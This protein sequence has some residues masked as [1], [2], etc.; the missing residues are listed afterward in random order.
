ME[1]ITRKLRFHFFALIH[2]VDLRYPLSNVVHFDNYPAVW[3]EHFILNGL[4]VD[5]PVLHASTRS[6]IG[7]ARAAVPDMV[8]LTTR[9]RRILERAAR[10]GIGPDFTVPS[11]MPGERHASCSFAVRLL[12]RC[13]RG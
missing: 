13:G 6:A 7:F 10:E 9:R 12:A 5:D 2:H 4:Y 1:E 11:N 8:R 3:S